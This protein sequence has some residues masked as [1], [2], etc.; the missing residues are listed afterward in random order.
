MRDEY[1]GDIKTAGFQEVRVVDEATFPIEWL[2]ND[3][4]AQ[5]I[6]KDSKIPLEEV[7]NVAGSVVSIKVHAAKST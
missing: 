6:V 2:T 3:P 1:I 5:A 7:Q 4:T